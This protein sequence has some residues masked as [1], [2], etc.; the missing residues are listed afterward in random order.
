MRGLFNKPMKLPVAFGAC[1]FS[2]KRH[3]L[4]IARQI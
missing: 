1:S 4:G 3:A 2:A